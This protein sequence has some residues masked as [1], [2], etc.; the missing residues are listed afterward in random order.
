MSYSVT[1]PST[2]LFLFKFERDNRPWV[3]WKE[4]NVY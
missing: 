1:R 2:R 4:L 3:P